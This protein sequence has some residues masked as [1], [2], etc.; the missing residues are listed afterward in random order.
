MPAVRIRVEERPGYK[1]A[2][3]GS[4]PYRQSTDVNWMPATSLELRPGRQRLGRD[5][6]IIGLNATRPEIDNGGRPS[7][8]MGSLAY[9]NHLL[10]LL[11]AN[12]HQVV[13]GYPK[14]GNGT[15][16]IQT[17]TPGGTISGGTWTITWGGETTGAMAY[18]ATASEVQAYLERFASVRPGDIVVAGGPVSSGAMTLTFQGQYAA[19]NPA[20]VTVSAASLTGSS[21]TLTPTTTTAGVVGTNVDSLGNGAV[22]GAYIWELEARNSVY[23]Q[24]PRYEPLS[25]TIDGSY[26]DPELFA[27]GVGV[28]GLSMGSDGQVSADLIALYCERY[29]TSPG[30][31]P[32]YDSEAIRP[33]LFSDLRMSWLSNSGPISG[34]SW[35]TACPMDVIDDATL[36]AGHP[37]RLVFTGLTMLSGSV[38]SGVFDK[39]DWD[40][41]QSGAT[42]PMTATYRSPSKIS[43]TGVPYRLTLYAPGCQLGADGGPEGLA[44]KLRHGA[45]YQWMA[46]YNASAGYAH[47]IIL[48]NSLSAVDTFA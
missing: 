16:E 39:D 21:P 45:S 11:L 17:I 4:S 46:K 3:T 43:T 2:A 36:V 42:F 19:T 15:N 28:T 22:S 25:L 8:S 26:D 10:R 14:A 35:Q 41:M 34:F 12:G 6:E 29:L 38:D 37:G 1:G 40:Y 24:R 18:N 31:S 7:G 48:V 33:L 47:R 5:D 13:S 32:S 30:L 20:Q 23:G 27:Q 9:A 44:A